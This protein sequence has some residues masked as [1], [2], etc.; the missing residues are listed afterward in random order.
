MVAPNP[1]FLRDVDVERGLELLFLAERA[2][3]GRGEAALDR[4][5]LSAAD[6]RLLYLLSRRDGIT[7]VELAR[8]LGVSKQAVSRQLQRLVAAGRVA[9]EPATD[10]RRKLRLRA[11]APARQLVEEVVTLQRRQLR[12]AFKKAGG[13]AVLGFERVLAELAGDQSRHVPRRDAA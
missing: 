5:G 7:A 3:R 4:L 8:L 9:V 13:E 6:F 10:D 12:A 1:L 2:L 11:A